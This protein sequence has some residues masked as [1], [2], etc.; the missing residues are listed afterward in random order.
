MKH[1]I[2]GSGITGLYLAYKLITKN[3]TSPHNIIIIE[4]S[5]TYGGRIQTFKYKGFSYD[6]GAGRLANKHKF[7][8]Q[9]IQELNLNDY[10]FLIILK[11]TTL[12]M[13]SYLM[14]NNY[15]N[16]INLNLHHLK[17]YGNTLLTINLLLY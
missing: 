12:L 7:V 11:K 2:I 5:K 16:I 3:I 13:V 8:M 4:K 15:L 14:N 6:V 9:L 10:I 1:I 17:I